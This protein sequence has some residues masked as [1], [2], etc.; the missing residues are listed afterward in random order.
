VSAALVPAPA[1]ALVERPTPEGERALREAFGYIGRADAAE[2]RRA[3][4]GDWRHFGAWCLQ[5]GVSSLPATPAILAVYLA[6]HADT[7][8]HK[9]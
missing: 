9:C 1:A 5:V 2:T 8:T 7:G 3:Y 6:A 4:A